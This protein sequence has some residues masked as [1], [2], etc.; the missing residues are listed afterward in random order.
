M[1]D[2]PVDQPPAG[3]RVV[4]LGELRHD[5]GHLVPAFAAPHV[6]DHVGVAPLRHL[7]QQKRFSRCRTPG[8]AALPPEHAPGTSGRATRCP[9][10][11]WYGGGASGRPTGTWSADRPVTPC[12]RI[13]VPAYRGRSWAPAEP[14]SPHGTTA[15]RIRPAARAHGVRAAPGVRAGRRAPRPPLTCSPDGR[16]LRTARR[17]RRVLRGPPAP[18]EEHPG[19]LDSG[20]SRPSNTAPS[21]PGPNR[22]D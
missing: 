8:T 20:R 19:A 14:P 18:V 13:G 21:N 6:D 3:A 16:G 11:Q 5:L 17:A 12:T 15:R 1:I 2:R 22:A 7:L 10:A 9:V 4:E